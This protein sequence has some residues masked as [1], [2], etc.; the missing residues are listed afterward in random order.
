MKKQL[1]PLILLCCFVIAG[2]AQQNN[3]NPFPKTITVTGSAEM[4]VIPDEV[5]VTVVLREYQKKGEAKKD[6][7]TIKSAFL[8]SCR[9]AGISDSAI[10][11]LSYSGYNSYYSLRKK[12]KDS[13]LFAGISYL[14]KFSNSEQMDNLVDKLDDQATQGFEISFT[15]HSRMTAFRKQ[16]KID[17]IKAAKAKA[18]YLTTAIDEQLGGAITVKEPEEGNNNYSA[19]NRA[20]NGANGI[21]KYEYESFKSTGIVF[22]KIKLRYEVTVIFALK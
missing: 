7:E 10:S 12:Q 13:D 11:I 20:V 9:Q 1:L 2:K 19:S 22:R 6:I 18:E 16:L 4:E 21:S 3:S 14:I 8:E 5:Y 15:S 17:A